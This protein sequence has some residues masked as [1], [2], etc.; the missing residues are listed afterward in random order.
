MTGPRSYALVAVQRVDADGAPLVPLEV[1][2]VEAGLHP[3]LVHRLVALGALEPATAT[4]RPMFRRD[5]AAHL[6][7][8][9]RLRHDLGLNYTGALLAMD[10]LARIEALEGALGHIERWERR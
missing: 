2:A 1:V 10:L 9:Q 6:A 7:R 4:G 5:A 3:D 8:L